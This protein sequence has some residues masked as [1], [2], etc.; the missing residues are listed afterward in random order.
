MSPFTTA[1][2]VCGVFAAYKQQFS[3]T[4][5]DVRLAELFSEI[6]RIA[7]NTQVIRAGNPVTL[8][9]IQPN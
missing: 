3:L 9:G 2:K 7:K 6:L 1:C 4:I 5:S 8:E